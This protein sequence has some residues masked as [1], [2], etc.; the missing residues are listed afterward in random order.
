MPRETPSPIDLG[1]EP[2]DMAGLAWTTGV[3]TIAS[4]FLLATNAVS[5]RDWVA[6]LTPGTTQARALEA[7]EG[8]VQLTDAMGV[9]R[10]RAWLHDLWKKA[11]TA[12]F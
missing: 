1:E 11:E 5:L 3:I 7:A 10:P 2:L 8:W 12:T 9:A 6:D 4:L